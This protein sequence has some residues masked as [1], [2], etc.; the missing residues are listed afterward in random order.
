MNYIGGTDKK[1]HDIIDDTRE[2][3]LKVR[4]NN[5]E[6]EVDIYRDIF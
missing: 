6:V 2:T 5:Y 4:E 3:F 1:K